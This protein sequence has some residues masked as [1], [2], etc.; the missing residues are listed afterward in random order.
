[1]RAMGVNNISDCDDMKVHT[2]LIE[3]CHCPVVVP[4]CAELVHGFMRLLCGQGVGSM[5]H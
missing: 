4:V 3:Y 1:M 2:A 5:H